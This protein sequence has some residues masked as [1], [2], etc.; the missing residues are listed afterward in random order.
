MLQGCDFWTNHF[1]VQKFKCKMFQD[2]HFHQ[3]GMVTDVSNRWIPKLWNYFHPAQMYIILQ[4]RANVDRFDARV[5]EVSS[6]WHPN[7]SVTQKPLNVTGI[8]H[9]HAKHYFLEKNQKI[10]GEKS[11]CFSTYATFLTIYSCSV[12]LNHSFRI[13]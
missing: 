5:T 13:L 12:L 2:V 9:P 4:K 6:L 3:S 1:L 11:K 10:F 8:R 7:V